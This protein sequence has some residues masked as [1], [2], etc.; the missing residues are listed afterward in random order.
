MDA[1]GVAGSWRRIRFHGDPQ[2][3]F[4]GGHADPRYDDFAKGFGVGV[5]LDVD[6]W[7]SD[8]DLFCFVADAADDE[9]G[10]EWRFD[11]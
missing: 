7:P 5:Q 9:F 3:L 2:L 1:D 11:G 6:R 8:F 4:A 10:I